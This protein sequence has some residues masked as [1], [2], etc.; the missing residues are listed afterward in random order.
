[1][2]SWARPAAPES[3]ATSSPLDPSLIPSALPPPGSSERWPWLQ[4]LRRQDDPDLAS[5]LEALERGWLAAE[6][7]LLAVLAE[8]LDGTG[9]E[10]L[11]AWWVGGSTDPTLL[12]VIGRA[13][14]PRSAALVRQALAER[15]DPASRHPLL[16][17]LGHQ[18]DPTDF[19][20]LARL[21]LEA[22]PLPLRLAALEGLALGLSAWPLPLLRQHLLSLAADLQPQLAGQAVDLLARL[23]RGRWALLP[24]T[25]RSLDPQVAERL[26]RRWAALAPSPL[27][28][29]VHGRAGG[30][31]PEELQ[32]LASDLEQL[33]GRPVRIQ[34][35]TG[36]T[37]TTPASY[38][39]LAGEAAGSADPQSWLIP[40]IT[41]VPLFLLPGSHVRIDVP[42]I[43]AAWSAYGP[44]RRL[45]FLGA[46]P[47]WQQALAAEL[48][49]MVP[50]QGASSAPDVTVPLL[51]HH[52][53]ND[54]LGSRYLAHLQSVTQ[55]RC[56][57]TPYSASDLKEIK[58]ANHSGV[59]PLALAANRLT[60]SLPEQLGA[61]LA[62]RP[63]FRELLLGQLGAL[64]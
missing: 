18:R 2:P 54:G 22:G 42:A 40:W 11:L 50:A 52:P 29:I 60:E 47:L 39:S 4:R 14:T 21:S 6:S 32:S 16:P 34:A 28:L 8:R 56:L 26:R 62:A 1:M 10:R 45:P 59:L 33:R 64:P 23:P 46:W 13:R 24:L 19:P 5:W 12:S 61:P 48:A 44:V 41:V 35:L 15:T 38:E 57:P 3:G 9:S 63:R 30:V 58:L 20:L 49:A 55:A 53:L 37:P 43:A 36:S 31:I 17:L 27:L 7:D 51:L 25:R